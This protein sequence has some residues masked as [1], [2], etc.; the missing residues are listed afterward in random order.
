MAFKFFAYNSD[1]PKG[2]ALLFALRFFLEELAF[3]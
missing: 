1:S 2:T 3:R